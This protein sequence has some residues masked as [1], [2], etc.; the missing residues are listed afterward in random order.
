MASVGKSISR[1]NKRETRSP[2]GIIILISTS[3][4]LWPK[5]V[6]L[7]CAPINKPRPDQ[8][9]YNSVYIQCRL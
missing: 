3:E 2:S 4:H 5:L 6:L 9:V 8:A 7:K 1:I